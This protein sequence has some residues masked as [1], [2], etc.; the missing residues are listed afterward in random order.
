MVFLTQIV[1]DA[2]IDKTKEQEVSQG[3]LHEEFS[4]TIYGTRWAGEDI[5]RFDMP[6]NEMPPDVA[7]R[8]INDELSLDGRPALNLASFVTTFMEPEAEKLISENASKNFM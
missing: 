1:T 7:Y 3:Q 5:P 6:E 2:R 4:T 8:L